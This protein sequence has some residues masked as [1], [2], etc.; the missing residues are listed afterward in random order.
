M[1]TAHKEILVD[2]DDAEANAFMENFVKD[3]S[4]ILCG[5]AFHFVKLAMRVQRLVNFST[6]SPGYNIYVNSNEDTRWAFQGNCGS[7]F[8]VLCDLETFTKL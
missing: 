2:F 3:V 1:K 5:C 7:S 4:N 8:F 6:V